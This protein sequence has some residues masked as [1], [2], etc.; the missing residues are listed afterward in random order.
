M[1]L[2]G[3]MAS[4]L[5]AQESLQEALML[6]V[7]FDRSQ[8]TAHQGIVGNEMVDQSTKD[9]DAEVCPQNND[10]LGNR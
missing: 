9:A 6:P 2:A 5:S 3:S 1:P 4:D 7:R 10:K 8:Q